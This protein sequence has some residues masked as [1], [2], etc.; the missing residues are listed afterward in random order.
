MYT[1]EYITPNSG[2][3]YITSEVTRTFFE[4]IMFNIKENGFFSPLFLLDVNFFG[5]LLDM[6]ALAAILTLFLVFLFSTL[7]QAEHSFKEGIVKITG[8]TLKALF[9]FLLYRTISSSLYILY[10]YNSNNDKLQISFWISLLVVLILFIIFVS[11]KTSRGSLQSRY[12]DFL[13]NTCKIVCITN[14]RARVEEDSY[15]SNNATIVSS[16]TIVLT[17][18]IHSTSHFVPAHKRL[19]I[20]SNG[21]TYKYADAEIPEEIDDLQVGIEIQILEMGRAESGEFLIKKYN[22]LP[23]KNK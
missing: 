9:A 12:V 11:Y 16:G 18:W 3:A 8:Y 7:F 13:D 22:I 2:N 6:T 20:V 14:I 1:F 17:P 19:L 10:C 21:D 4:E 5:M 23:E 15:M